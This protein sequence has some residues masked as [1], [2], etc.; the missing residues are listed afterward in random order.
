MPQVSVLQQCLSGGRR[1]IGLLLGAGCPMAVRGTNGGSLIPD[2]AGISRRVREELIGCNDLRDSFET[3]YG[4][5][6]NEGNRC[7]TVE[8]LLTHIRALAAVAGND[9]VRDLSADQ[10]DCLD[11]RICDLIHEVVNVELPDER[12]PYHQLALWINAIPRDFPIE[13]FT[14][15]YDLLMEQRWRSRVFHT[16]MG[17]LGH[18]DL[19]S[20]LSRLSRI[21]HCLSGHVCGSSMVQ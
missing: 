12:T 18:A 11:R 14:T 9:T 10:L 17:F 2:I 3:A 6:K 7:P 15:N 16:S 8:D 20:I 19:S 1:P 13:I 5:L 21:L 4:H